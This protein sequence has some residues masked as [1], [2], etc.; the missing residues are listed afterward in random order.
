M[1]A[2]LLC[3]SPGDGTGRGTRASRAAA[4][5]TWAA[6]SSSGRYEAGSLL[7]VKQYRLG[8]GNPTEN[9]GHRVDLRL[10]EQDLL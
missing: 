5:M 6:S 9:F 1:P 3:C 7:L 2:Q 4:T 8:T 10:L